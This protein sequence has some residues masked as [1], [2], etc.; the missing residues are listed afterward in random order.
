MVLEFPDW[1]VPSKRLGNIGEIGLD[2]HDLERSSIDFVEL[3]PSVV[4]REGR[5][6]GADKGHGK[7]FAVVYVCSVA[8]GSFETRGGIVVEDLELVFVSVTKEDAGNSIGR[9][10][11]DDAVE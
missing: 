5:D 2:I 3:V 1:C 7:W 8:D 10:A 6:G 4:A 11:A 9:E